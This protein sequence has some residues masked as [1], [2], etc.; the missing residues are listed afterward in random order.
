MESIS[1]NRAN[2]AQLLGLVAAVQR[3]PW[4]PYKAK[5]SLDASTPQLIKAAIIEKGGA[6]TQALDGTYT[7]AAPQN[8]AWDDVQTEL[9]FRIGRHER[10][11]DPAKRA[12]ADL[13]ARDLLSGNGTAQTRLTYAAQV[14]FGR[15]QLALM[16]QAAYLTALRALDLEAFIPQVQQTTDALEK[17]VGLD[18]SGPSLPR[19][20]RIELALR[21][22][23]FT[24][25]WAY[26][27]LILLSESATADDDRQR[28]AEL[29]APF[30][31]LH[32]LVSA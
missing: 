18:G 22:M 30:A 4:A 16:A 27:A 8:A 3:D 28:A 32:A 25:A 17:A 31:A 6:L 24:A 5:S 10:S 2:A 13:L 15:N 14:A 23:R 20:E 1:L 26:E 12:H 11:A 21:D 7:G 19:A 29:A 9:A